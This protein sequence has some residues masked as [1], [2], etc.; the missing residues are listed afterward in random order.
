MFQLFNIFNA[1]S[2]ER[3]AFANLFVNPWLWSAVGLSVVL[4]V[5]VVYVPILQLAFS[6]VSL[7]IGDWIT[8]VAMAS[9]VLWLRELTKVVALTRIRKFAT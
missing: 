3:S 6:T 1:R 9:S 8:C 4:H 5:A 7:S 2:D